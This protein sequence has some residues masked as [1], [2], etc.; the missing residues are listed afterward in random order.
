MSRCVKMLDQI[1]IVNLESTCREEKPPPK[2]F[3][4]MIE[5]GIC[6]LEVTSGG[7]HVRESIPISP[8]DSRISEYCT[9]LTTITQHMVGEGISFLEAFEIPKNKYSSRLDVCASYGDDDHKMILKQCRRRVVAYPFEDISS[10]KIISL[11][12]CL[13]FQRIPT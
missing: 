4:E 7:I 10:I 3:G 9:H 12:A 5:I 11:Q 6:P 2:Q 13:A 1:N 8:H